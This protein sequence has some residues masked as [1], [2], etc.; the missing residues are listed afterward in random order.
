MFTRIR[1]HLRTIGPALWLA[2]LAATPAPAVSVS[3][4]YETEVP[5]ERDTQ[6]QRA[7]AFGQAM[8]V[9]LVRLTGRLDA[10]TS[11]ETADIRRAAERYVQQ[12]RMTREGRLW[13][14]FDGVSL[15]SALAER[16]L[17]IWGAERPAVLL[18]LAVDRGGGRR[19]VLS[20]EDEVR[21]RMSA[22]LRSRMQALAE[23][24][25]L[26]VVL[27]LMDAQDRSVISFSEVWGGFEQAL[28]TAGQ[29][30]GSDSV[31]LGRLST[32]A[33]Y[34]TRWTLFSD[35]Q[36]FRWTGGLDDGIQGASDRFARRYAVTT[37]AAVQ[38]EVGVA[39]RG[40]GSLSDYG[41]VL[42][43]LEGLTA[44]KSV[45]VR[46]LRDETVVFGLDL[47][48][49]LDNVDRAIR[50]GNLLRP[51]AG[52]TPDAI[53]PDAPDIRPVLLTYRLSR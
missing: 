13:V 4:L 35:D 24:R 36:S 6:A 22:E 38:G 27:P 46:R 19:F 7:A 26:P 5:M 30:Y 40:I 14:A 44:V 21:D 51:E 34:R 10:A 50:L 45:S 17:P 12:Y 3:G 1:T 47:I 37:G 23:F 25:G 53:A 43:Y 32:D 42:D 48:G 20:A 9:V 11:E 28:L 16:G 39:V 15:G 31:L 49:S 41:R 52:A 2:L 33:E 29:R 18:V 8:G